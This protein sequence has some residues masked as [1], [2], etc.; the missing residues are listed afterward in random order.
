MQS[1]SSSTTPYCQ[2]STRDKKLAGVSAASCV[3]NGL[4]NIFVIV[5]TELVDAPIASQRT[6]ISKNDAI[7]TW[8][9]LIKVVTE[10]S[11]NS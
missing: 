3:V 1:L 5:I 4:G 6:K 9:I 2:T 11:S 7:A 8:T 10:K